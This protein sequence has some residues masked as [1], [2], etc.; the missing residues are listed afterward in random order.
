[1]DAEHEREVRQRYAE[2]RNDVVCHP[3]KQ[4]ASPCSPPNPIYFSKSQGEEASAISPPLNLVPVP[5]P[6]ILLSIPAVEAVQGT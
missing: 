4:V 3:D 6:R 2:A 1:M 5:A